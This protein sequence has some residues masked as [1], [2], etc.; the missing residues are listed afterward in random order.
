MT[1]TAFV[2]VLALVCTGHAASAQQQGA[3]ALGSPLDRVRSLLQEFGPPVVLVEAERPEHPDDRRA[4]VLVSKALA[5]HGVRC[6]DGPSTR[7]R[8][9]DLAD[10]AV[11]SGLPPER[12]REILDRPDADFVARVTMS[13]KDA[14]ATESYGIPIA[15]RECTIAIA[16]VHASDQR[17][18]GVG[19][20]SAVARS[21]ST[22]AASVD[23]EVAA[24][25]GAGGGIAEAAVAEWESI[26]RGERPWVVELDCPTAADVAEIAGSLGSG[27]A[28]ILENRQGVRALVQ[29]S[30]DEAA[31]WGRGGG[32]GQVLVLVRRPGYLLVASPPGAALPWAFIAVAAVA[33]AIAAAV[34]LRLR[35]TGR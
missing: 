20:A 23:A 2:A 13:T 12:V 24:A 31:R 29:V 16:M 5:D 8:R 22:A 21:A 17:V 3:A 6:A 18:V 1:A 35:R 4:S 26:A 15:A 10:A 7:G 32:A 14:G 25:Q 9:R 33:M 19:P 30:A 34:A 28:V 27:D 11:E